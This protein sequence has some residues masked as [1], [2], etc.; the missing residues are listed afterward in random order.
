[1][2]GAGCGVRHVKPSDSAATVFGLQFIILERKN[3]YDFVV[4]MAGLLLETRAAEI[5]GVRLP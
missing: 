1:M 5:P 2:P 3:L 4:I